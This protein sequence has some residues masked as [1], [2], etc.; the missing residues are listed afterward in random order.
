MACWRPVARSLFSSRPLLPLSL[1]AP[2]VVGLLMLAPAPVASGSLPRPVLGKTVNVEPVNGIVYVKL[3]ATFVRLM[4]ARQM[5]VGST[6][7]LTHGEA[8]LT[9]A[10]ARKGNA[11]VGDFSGGIIKILQDPKQRGRVA[12][13]IVNNLSA[14]RECSSAVT[15][16]QPA[17]HLSST[18]LGRLSGN[19]RGRYTTYGEYS[20][21][22]VRGTIWSVTNRCDGTLTEVSRGS[23]TIRDFRRHKTISLHAPECRREC[24]VRGGPAYLAGAEG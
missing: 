4:H 12:L 20:A 10:T 3:V 15:A 19:A 23:V 8:K 7:D 6:L 11:Q 24:L 14:G 22:T 21:A 2:A 17:R 13:N 18:V 5:P 9:T 16:A 1:L